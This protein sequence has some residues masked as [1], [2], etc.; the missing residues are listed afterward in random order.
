LAPSSRTEASATIAEIAQAK[1]LSIL[2]CPQSREPVEVVVLERA[3]RAIRRGVVWSPK[4]GA[5]VGRIEDFQLDF[6]RPKPFSAGE[7]AEAKAET[8]RGVLPKITESINAWTLVPFDAADFAYGG[9]KLAVDFPDM[10]V[11]EHVG[12]SIAFEAAGEIEL[13]LFAHPWS[14][15]VEIDYGVEV[16]SLDL[17]EPHTVIPRPLKLALGGDRRRVQIK[18]VGKSDVSFGMQCLFGGYRRKTE[19]L[20]PL[21]YVRDVKVRGAPFL[22]SFKELLAATPEN[23]ILLDIGGG[24]RQVE[25]ARYVNL[26]YADYIEPDM[27]GDATGLPFA[28][29]SIDAIYSTGVFEHIHDP[30]S[31]GAE[32]ARVLKPGGKAVIAWAFMQPIHSEGHH[33]Y[34]ATPWGV[35]RAFK[36]LKVNRMWYDTSFAFLV[37]WG[38]SVSNLRAS[39]PE[40]EIKAVVDT[41]RRWDAVIDE[42]HKP[43]MANGVWCEFQK[44]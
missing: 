37:E 44:V 18:I 40:A 11:I 30:F 5:M 33:F 24:N 17:Y 10:T 29:N 9:T 32:V 28:D 4:L 43:Y 7:F 2:C 34:N 41:L 13:V 16:K 35:E 3:G 31:A 19:Q 21:R 42:E 23:G 36:G 8:A 12:S 38:A 27:I 26:D 15:V 20:I 25:D 1:L 14:G 6:V 22:D 39:I